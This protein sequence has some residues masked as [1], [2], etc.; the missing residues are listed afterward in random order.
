MQQRA[1]GVC[2]QKHPKGHTQKELLCTLGCA[3]AAVPMVPVLHTLELL[4]SLHS[5]NSPRSP[6]AACTAQQ[7]GCGQLQVE[8]RGAM[9]TSSTHR[10][11]CTC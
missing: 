10:S 5:L 9:G 6:A 11:C 3:Q 8:R 2:A 4:H 1:V 7:A